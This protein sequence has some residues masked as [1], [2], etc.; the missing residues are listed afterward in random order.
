[1]LGN[2]N[3][4]VATALDISTP[5]SDLFAS[6]HKKDRRFFSNQTGCEGV[7]EI[8]MGAGYIEYDSG[9]DAK[10]Q[11]VC[12]DCGGTGFNKKLQ[13]YKLQNKNIFDIWNMTID[14]AILYFNE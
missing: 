1:M 9:Y 10:I 13:K 8:C 3:S 6:K 11:L 4:S 14:E 7:C 12:K 2:K 5:I